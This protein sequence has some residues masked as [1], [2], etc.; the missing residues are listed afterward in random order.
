[1][2]RRL[3]FRYQTFD[4][5]PHEIRLRLLRDLDQYDDPHDTAKAAGIS[6]KAWPLFGMV[7]ASSEILAQLMLDHEISGK[8]ILEIGCGMALVSHVL[9]ARGADI[10][11]M[12]IH[13]VV[14]EFL[15]DN[16]ALNS[17]DPIPFMNASWGDDTVDLGR[18][19]LIL[20]AD[21]LYE[22]KHVKTLAPFLDRHAGENTEIIILDPDR[23]QGDAFH[24]SMHLRGFDCEGFRPGLKDHLEIEYSGR[25]YRYYRA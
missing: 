14:G 19:D 3:K 11:A 25:G 20:G 23:G 17:Q 16:T 8:R 7:W 5:G 1:M 12:D 18:F 9:N 6:R 21:V 13:P 15:A 24:E 10:T 2:F 4:V 22:P